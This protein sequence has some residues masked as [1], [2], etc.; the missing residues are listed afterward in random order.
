MPSSRA[1]VAATTDQPPRAQVGLDRATLLGEIAAAV[2]RHPGRQRRV[3]LGDEPAGGGRHVLDP[4]S[5]PDEGEGADIL[6][7]QVGEQVGR[8]GGGGPPDR[9]AALAEVGHERRLPQ[10]QRDLAARGVVAADGRHAQ[11]GEATRRHLGVGHRRGGQHERG[12]RAVER[13]D[14]A[15]PPQHLAHVRAEHAPIVMALVDH[16]VAQGRPERRPPAVRGQHRAVQHVGVRRGRTP[17]S[18]ATTRAPPGCCHRRAWSPGRRDPRPAVR[19]AGRGRAP[20]WARDRGLRPRAGHAD[21][22]RRGSRSAPAA[23]RPATCPTPCPTPGRRADLN[24][25][26]R[27][28]IAGA[29]TVARSRP[30]R[31][32]PRRRR[33]PRTASHGRRPCGSAAP[34]RAAGARRGR[35]GGTTG[36]GRA[37]TGGRLRSRT[38]ARFECGKGDRRRR[39]EPLARFSARPARAWFDTSGSIRG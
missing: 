2:R 6:D 27:R 4:A 39:P 37:S 10:R 22:G 25:P 24:G 21:R 7:D 12:S 19:P 16:D 26:H 35:T 32:R 1:F 14:P 33:Q 38:G 18:H 36:R 34:R 11:P 8:L 15:Q 5:G 17:R 31:T 23:G 9:R 13:G 20:W 29:A 28:R 3:D 30:A